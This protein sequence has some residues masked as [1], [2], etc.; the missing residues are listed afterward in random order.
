MMYAKAVCMKRQTFRSPISILVNGNSIHF[1]H[2]SLL[3]MIWFSPLDLAF[4]P[5]TFPYFYFFNQT[6]PP[7]HFE[8]GDRLLNDCAIYSKR[9]NAIS[10]CWVFRQSVYGFYHSNLPCRI[11]CRSAFLDFCLGNPK[12]IPLSL[13]DMKD[14]NQCAYSHNW[15]FFA[16]PKWYI[17]KNENNRHLFLKRRKIHSRF[18]S[19]KCKIFFFR[20]LRVVWVFVT[21][22]HWQLSDNKHRSEEITFS[23]HRHSIIACWYSRFCCCCCWLQLEILSIC[24]FH[25]LKPAKPLQQTQKCVLTEKKTITWLTMSCQHRHSVVF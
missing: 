22:K 20:F 24:F 3:W 17:N 7:N 23:H 1:A 6:H 10:L 19:S 18:Q 9:K 13:C 4:F 5:S 2:F 11:V 16:L 8:F 15:F 25:C 12:R 21:L 14:R